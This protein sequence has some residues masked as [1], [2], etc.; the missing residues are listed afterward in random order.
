VPK[1]P[2][3]ATSAAGHGPHS[4]LTAQI[5]LTVTEADTAEAFRSGNVPVLATPRL[6]ALCEEATCRATDDHLTSAQASVATR[7]QFDH[8]APVAVGSVVLAEATLVK[9]EGRRLIFTVS[10]ARLE[11]DGGGLVGAGRVTRVMVD[12]SVFLAKAGV[13]ATT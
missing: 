3:E 8:L 13:A 9:V 1:T 5:E 6:I 2:S 7:V 12:R 4:G 11:G 10:A